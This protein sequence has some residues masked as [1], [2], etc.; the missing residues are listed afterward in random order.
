MC[1]I[2]IC[3]A[4]LARTLC[5]LVAAAGSSAQLLTAVPDTLW[6]SCCSPQVI[7][8]LAHTSLP[9]AQSASNLQLQHRAWL[10]LF[11]N[12]KLLLPC[13]VCFSHSAAYACCGKTHN[14][15]GCWLRDHQPAACSSKRLSC[16][17]SINIWRNQVCPK[18]GATYS[19]NA[20][21]A[22]AVMRLHQLHRLLVRSGCQCCAGAIIAKLLPLSDKRHCGSRINTHCAVSCVMP[23]QQSWV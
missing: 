16:E 20:A 21:A 15:M 4:T 9:G 8:R 7:C 5:C 18:L 3:L 2:M 19:R 10:C 13:W 11:Q 17:R 22:S 23:C 14:A 1:T 12:S 6:K